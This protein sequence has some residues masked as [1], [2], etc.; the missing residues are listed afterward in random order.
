MQLQSP[1][2]FGD[3]LRRHR[4][5]AGLTQEELAARA[6]LSV[7]EVSDLERGVR[8]H[9]HGDTVGLLV[10]ALGLAQAAAISFAT[11]ARR[12]V[13]QPCPTTALDRGQPPLIGRKREIDLIESLLTGTGPPM[14]VLA[15]EPGIGKSRLLSEA[16]VRAAARGWVVLPG[17][18]QRRT[19]QEPY[20]PVLQALDYHLQAQSP[21]QRVASLQGCAWLVRL[22][23]ELESRGIAPLPAWTLPPEQERRLMFRAV[24]HYVVNVAGPA[25][26]I[27]LLDDLQWAG[28][29][30]LDLLSMLVRP[31][32]VPVRIVGTY[33]DTDVGAEHPL[34]T[35]L[36][37]LA[38]AGLVAQHVVPPL[39][40][41]EAAELLDT[42]LVGAPA[43]TTDVR[44]RVLQ[45]AS[46]VPFFLVSCAQALLDSARSGTTAD[47]V[48]WSIVQG[49]RQRLAMLPVAAQEIVEVAAV[50]GRQ[51]SRV[52]LDTVLERP[53]VEMVA[54]LESAVTGQLL[55]EA[56]REGYRFT[57]DLIRE[58]VEG[59]LGSARRVML[60][61]RVAEALEATYAGNLDR[62]SSQIAAHLDQ[63]GRV[64]Q[65]IQAYERA[66][67]LAQRLYAN[68]DAIAHYRRAIALL[69]EPGVDGAARASDATAARLWEGLADLLSLT[70]RYEEACDALDQLFA[71]LPVADALSRSRVLRK[72]ATAFVRQYALDDA[73]RANEQA[74]A[75]LATDPS[76]GAEDWHQA[77]IEIRLQ[78]R[79]LHYW[80][81]EV[82][83]IG[84]LTEDLR[85]V[86]AR[87]GTP[88]QRARFL[89]ANWYV[90]GRDRFVIADKTLADTLA[91]L[92]A[93]QEV[94]DTWEI[95][96]A[97]FEVGFCY[98][99]RDALD[100]AEA[101]LR[102]SQ[103]A[104]EQM[105]DILEQARCLP[106]LTIVARKRGQVDTVEALA[107]QSLR[108]M[109]DADCLLY[110][111]TAQANLAWA[112]YRR[113]DAEAAR[114]Y[115]NAALAAWRDTPAY[116]FQ[117]AALWPMLALDLDQESIGAAI[118]HARAMLAPTQQRLR[119]D[120]AGDLTQGIAAWDGCDRQTA[121]TCLRRA[122][123]I[124][125][126]LCYI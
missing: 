72:T 50:V 24:V 43:T 34:S 11:S 89:N 40:S 1:S 71:R 74:E 92:A 23:P 123:E 54:A 30:A 80:R 52:V 31:G 8:R 77:W 6:G 70:G 96:H 36:A 33:R 19:G 28:V 29:D 98:L 99:W 79:E 62:A 20:A 53:E 84:A 12:H 87:Y 61:R 83:S 105:G 58:V 18:S 108:V 22:F 25:G 115:G 27:L 86:V 111:G 44:Q 121:T 65:A 97:Q 93:W 41:T 124:A 82:P 103:A 112:A 14:L 120:L 69:E 116:P 125:R 60:H 126:Q 63:A 106:Y 45:R 17:S 114:T 57:H 119:D 49:L 3:T 64:E 95:A 15:G 68:A 76:R 56:G 42:L 67:K 78:R 39:P 37:D 51:V 5:A 73:L 55:S 26:T 66:A 47:D 32:A 94:G 7:R 117:W 81:A 91:G 16:A 102:A 113:G 75:L 9:P 104:Y 90:F 101:Y 46:G 107:T 109:A 88:Y 35:T 59:D 118:E 10:T 21:A 13:T 100:Q 122:S 110:A 48:P 4:L 85:P 38:H 2:T